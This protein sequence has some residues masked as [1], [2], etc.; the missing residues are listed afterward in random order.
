MAARGQGASS[1][2]QRNRA[3]PR[4]GACTEGQP[5]H[6]LARAPSQGAAAGVADSER[7]I[8]RIGA[9]LGGRKGESRRT[10]TDGGRDGC[11]GDGEGDGDRH[12]GCSGC[13]ESNGL[14]IAAWG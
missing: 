12:G 5:A 1:G 11:G 2:L 10:R 8:R 13:A 7:L 6:G 4:A 3:I 9:A 14:T